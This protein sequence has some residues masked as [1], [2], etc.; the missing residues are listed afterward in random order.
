MFTGKYTIN[1][2]EVRLVVGV[3]NNATVKAIKSNGKPSKEKNKLFVQCKTKNTKITCLFLSYSC[4][5][6]KPRLWK[7]D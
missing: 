3:P 2:F 5:A 6:S 4:S 1:I 7:Q